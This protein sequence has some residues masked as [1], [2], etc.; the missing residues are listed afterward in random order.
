MVSREGNTAGVML[1]ALDCGSEEGELAKNIEHA[2]ARRGIKLAGM[3]FECARWGRHLQRRPRDW[4]L[5]AGAGGQVTLALCCGQGVPLCAICISWFC[6][7]FWLAP[8]LLNAAADTVEAEVADT[9][10]AE[11]VVGTR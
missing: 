5:G 8:V 10:E 1:T 2:Q 6:L 9:V 11:V 4:G 7:S 3:N